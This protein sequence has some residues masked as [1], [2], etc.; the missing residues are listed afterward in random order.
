MAS[1]TLSYKAEALRISD[2]NALCKT[3]IHKSRG[4]NGLALANM[5]FVCR[6]GVATH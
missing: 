2:T 3:E 1:C 6:F 4:E 5:F